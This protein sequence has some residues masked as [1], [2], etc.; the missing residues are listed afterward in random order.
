MGLFLLATG[1][2][3]RAKQRM[4]SEG[5]I[6]C[7]SFHDPHPSQFEQCLGWLSRS[8]F[9]FIS[10][11]QVL[12]VARSGQS[13]GAG[14]VWVTLD[15]G[16]RGNLRLLP[17]LERYGVP[18]TI[19][20]ATGACET[21]GV[22]WWTIARERRDALPPPFRDNPELLWHVPETERKRI[23]DPLL[24]TARENHPRE[25]LKPSEI[26]RLSQHPLV[27]F[28]SHTVAHP[29][30]QCCD[31]EQ[32]N[33]ELRISRQRIEEWSGTPVR[34]FA[35][36]RGYFGARELEAVSRAGYEVA[37]TTRGARYCPGMDSPLMVPRVEL[38]D[39]STSAANVAKMVG[40][41]GPLTGWARALRLRALAHAPFPG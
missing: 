11:D 29:S 31:D 23:L 4:I 36:P 18:V 41:W 5:T 27:T 10:Q 3:G 28:G 1:I 34:V 16:W 17:I 25:A 2:V 13:G 26:G 6:L 19:F 24:Q 33:S 35:Y 37:V 15:D 21:S 32:L 20:V 22:F 40:L 9:S 39:D 8:G 38:G 14:C 12:D 30:L 7:I